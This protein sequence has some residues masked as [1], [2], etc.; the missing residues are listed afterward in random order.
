MSH[1]LNRPVWSALN[2]GWSHLAQGDDRAVRLDRGYGVFA[3][4]RD[5][6]VE[7]QAALKDLAVATDD[8]GLWV[9][10]P[11][12]WPTPAGMTETVRAACHQM[13]A[14][15]VPAPVDGFPAVLLSE[16]DAGEMYDLAIATKPGPFCV[17]TNRMSQFVG[18]KVDGRLVAMAGERMRIPGFAEVSAVCT[19]PEF[20][21][22]GYAA[23]LMKIVANRIIDRG[24]K[25]FLHTYAD[26]AGAIAL[27]ETLGFRY[28]ETMMLTI[29]K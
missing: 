9:V 13:I 12:A 28:R 20:R 15:A 26:N 2:S 23:G 25:P 7:N 6:S 29:F 5:A 4:A 24:E 11:E 16:D 21:G 10:E 1:P 3:A 14:D 8:M 18:I 19:Y 22:R 27:Y 17:H